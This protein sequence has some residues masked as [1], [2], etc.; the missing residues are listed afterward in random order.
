MTSL[1]WP[2]T[3]PP[4]LKLAGRFPLADRA[5]STTYQGPAHALHLHGYAGRMRLASELVDLQPGDLT[6]SP[7]G[8]PSAYDLAAPGQHWCVHFEAAATEED[9]IPLPLHL[10][11]GSGAPHA[12]D[13]L[14]SIAR[15]QARAADDPLCRAAA[16]VAFQDLLLWCAARAR[17]GQGGAPELDQLADEVAAIIESRLSE[18]LNA[19]SLAAATGR[20][21]HVIARAFRRRFGM[22]VPRYLLQRRMAHARYL[23]EATDLPVSAVGARVGIGDPQYFNKLARRFLGQSPSSIRRRA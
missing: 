17:T 13:R 4:R 8:R 2:L 20:P 1:P 11:L 3:T 7:A 18:R 19:H 23:L 15:L 16:A 21:Q 14:A 5:F 22:T 10:R 12:A 9:T 6:L